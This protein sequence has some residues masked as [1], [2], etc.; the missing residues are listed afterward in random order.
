MEIILAI[1]GFIGRTIAWFIAMILIDDLITGPATRWNDRRLAKM[2]TFHCGIRVV[3]GKLPGFTKA[4]RHGPTTISPG[5]IRFKDEA[6][7]VIDLAAH[8]RQPVFGECFWSGF[9]HRVIV[10]T[11]EAGEIEFAAR[12]PQMPTIR[13]TL[14]AGPSADQ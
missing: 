12:R 3:S 9:D 10:L 14:S 13:K 7:R 8:S 4:W 2:S 11:T 1:A 6:I 5:V